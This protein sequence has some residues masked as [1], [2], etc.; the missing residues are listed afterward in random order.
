M[1]NRA[2]AARTTGADPTT[3]NPQS[4]DPTVGRRRV[5][6]RP[7]S[8][9]RRDEVLGVAAELFAR[10]GF[11]ATTVRD[12]ADAAGMLSGSLYH[13]FDSKERIADELL[14]AFL[15]DL[16]ARYQEIVEAGAPPRVTFE[17]LVAVSFES[18]PRHRAAIVVYQQDAD[19]LAQLPGFDYLTTTSDQIER[20]WVDVLSRGVSSGELVTDNPKLTYQFVRDAIW[21]SVRWFR[22]DGPWSVT[23]LTRQ[24]LALVVDGLAPR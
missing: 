19:H 1:A 10:K 13:H 16:T 9:A 17:R 22:P 12:I 11:R 5:G 3:G 15:G 24:L 6:T 23:D 2:T 7:A 21:I 20:W 14:S 4:S 8:S 18:L